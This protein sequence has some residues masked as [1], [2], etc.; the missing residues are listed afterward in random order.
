MVRRIFRIY[1]LSVA[2]VSLVVAFRLP[3]AGVNPAHFGGMPLHPALVVSNLFLVQGPKHSILGPMWSLPYE[4]AMYLF[5]PWLFLILYPKKSLW[6]VAA[7]WSIS[8]LACLA[9]LRYEERPHDSNFLLYI[10][11]FLPGVIAYQLQR[12]KRRQLPAVFWPGVVIV[13]V[14]LFLYKQTPVLNLWYKGWIACFALG[15]AVPFFAQ[16]SAPWLTVPSY[17]IAKYSYGIYLTHLFC[18]W[19]MFERLHDVIPRIVRLPL[20]AGMVML[21][22]ILFY[23]FLEEPMTSLGKRVAKRFEKTTARGRFPAMRVS[24]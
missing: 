24:G 16:I 18:I 7:I 12:A 15:V 22:P 8:I 9:L 5:L 20:F 10:P 19:L 3:M 14:L 17:L 23:H 13:I 21:L 11:H 1:P 4:M 6:R 2:V